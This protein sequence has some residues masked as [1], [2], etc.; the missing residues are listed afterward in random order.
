M[1]RLAWQS[2]SDFLSW[3]RGQAG[4]SLVK[5]LAYR[6]AGIRTR[7]RL[8]PSLLIDSGLLQPFVSFAIEVNR[9]RRCYPL[10]SL[11][12]TLPMPTLAFYVK[13][14]TEVAF[15]RYL[16][17]GPL[18]AEPPEVLRERFD[19]G[20]GVCEWLLKGCEDNG[21]AVTVIDVNDAVESHVLDQVVTEIMAHPQILAGGNS[22]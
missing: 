1:A 4:T 20:L 21:T 15:S 5:K 17:R 14:F 19:D 13:T 9:E 3:R 18:T 2:P 10:D 8:G 12:R 22:R 6:L 7:C 16:D 11:L